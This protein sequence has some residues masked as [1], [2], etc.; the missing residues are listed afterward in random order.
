V[1][2]VLGRCDAARTEPFDCAQE[3]LALQKLVP[4]VHGSSSTSLRMHLPKSAGGISD[5]LLAPGS[6]F[7]EAAGL[8]A[9]SARTGSAICQA[10][11][12]GNGKCIPRPPR[13]M[14]TRM[15]RMIEKA[16]PFV[17]SV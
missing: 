4:M 13:V 2:A 10:A 14:V 17:V 3:C 6:R 5:R 16:A 1:R 12:G 9:A 7:W 8:Q 15:R 11:T